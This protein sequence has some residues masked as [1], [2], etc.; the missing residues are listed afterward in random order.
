M[1]RVVVFAEYVSYVSQCSAYHH[2]LTRQLAGFE[3]LSDNHHLDTEPPGVAGLMTIVNDTRC[4]TAS[5]YVLARVNDCGP[6]CSE[7]EVCNDC[8]PRMEARM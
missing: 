6:E 5:Q 3:K 1:C 4:Q 8:Y 7:I 2:E